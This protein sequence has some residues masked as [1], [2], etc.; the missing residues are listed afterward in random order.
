MV[1][2]SGEVAGDGALKKLVLAILLLL[3]VA[4][5][6]A[7]FLIVKRAT[8][9]FS[10]LG[11][12]GLRFTIA[13]VGVAPFAWPHLHRRTLG[14]GLAIGL[15]L[16]VSYLFQTYGL[17][18]TTSTN[19]GLITG[20]FVVFVPWMN[21]WLFGVRTGFWAWTGI[22]VSVGGLALLTGTASTLRVGDLFTLFCAACFGL[23]VTLLDH[24]APKHDAAGLAFGQLA[25]VAVICLIGWYAWEPASVVLP[26]RDIWKAIIVTGVICSGV[27]FFVQTLTQRHLTAIETALIIMTEPIFAA[28]VGRYWGQDRLSETQW[29]GAGLILVAMALVSLQPLLERLEARRRETATDSSRP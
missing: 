10:V 21:R 26:G 22:A 4:C 16:A 6:G 28:I 18:T 5:W 19:S 17:Q 23:Q 25:G 29:M 27:A 12:L 14:V 2:L 8:E 13:A 20:L 7:S 24:Y 15:V 3:V 9:E 11:F 1:G